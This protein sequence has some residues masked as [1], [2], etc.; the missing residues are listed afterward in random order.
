MILTKMQG[1]GND[2]IIFE[3]FNNS[4]SNYEEIA[5]KL[6][7]RH[8]GI[9]ADG[10]LVVK[11]SLN[12]DSKM[13]IFNS[14]GSQAEMCGN[15]IRCFAKYLFEKGIV[16]DNIMRVETIN[17][18]KT[19][20]LEIDGEVVSKLNVNM[21]HPEFKACLIPS[22]IDKE[23][24]VNE[25]IVI[26]NDRYNVTSLLLGV[27]HTILFVDDLNT[28]YI[29][30]VGPQIEKSCYFPHGT[31]VNFVKVLNRMEFKVITWER[32][33]GLTLACGTGACASLAACAL[34]GKTEKRAI[35]HLPGGEMT[36]EWDE[37]GNIQMT[38]PAENVFTVEYNI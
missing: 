6:C 14:D 24:I 33:A 23:Q 19:I 28:E 31:N 37:Y 7:D 15:G 21:G 36:I 27:P 13:L 4:Y 11:K 16:R 25:N 17:G 22:I 10:I 12:A 35:A 5:I 1:L 26:N 30:K 32:G 18:I 29:R 8:F 3:D 9:G 20:S 2:F 38:G 34:N